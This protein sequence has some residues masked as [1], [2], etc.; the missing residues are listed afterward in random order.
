[1]RQGSRASTGPD[2]R[3]MSVASFAD[4]EAGAR[5]EAP[6]RP[7]APGSGASLFK[8]QRKFMRLGR[9]I[10]LNTNSLSNSM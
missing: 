2:P 4:S 8:R 6:M 10:S 1:M 3:R 9:Y 7:N 5:E